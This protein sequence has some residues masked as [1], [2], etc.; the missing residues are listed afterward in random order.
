MVA[1]VEG[2][3]IRTEREPRVVQHRIAVP[4]RPPESGTGH[5]DVERGE[6]LDDRRDGRHPRDVHVQLERRVPRAIDGHVDP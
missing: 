6:T 1:H 4:P 5:G 2:A 3:P